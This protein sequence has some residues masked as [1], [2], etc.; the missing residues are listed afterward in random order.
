MSEMP[1]MEPEY[2]VIRPTLRGG[3]PDRLDYFQDRR[4][5]TRSWAETEVENWRGK[6]E[7]AHVVVRGWALLR[8]SETMPAN[9]PTRSELCAWCDDASRGSAFQQNGWY[10]SCGRLLHGFAFETT[11]RWRWDG[12]K[13]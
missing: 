5:N 1:D 2:G 7:R 12:K 3:T 13:S 6:G 9:A 4:L 8:P 10:P 11:N